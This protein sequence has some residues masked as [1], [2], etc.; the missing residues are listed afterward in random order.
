MIWNI[1]IIVEIII[2]II[3]IINPYKSVLTKFAVSFTYKK[4]HRKREN[5]KHP[6]NTKKQL[7]LNDKFLDS[8][9]LKEFA[10]DNF[11]FNENGRKFFKWVENNV[12]KREIARYEQ[13]LLYPY[14]FQRTCIA[15]T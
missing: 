9:K 2:I 10:D 15:D 8:Y 5:M 4:V 3:I 7:F 12:G 1:V 13:F 14:C 11:E 6:Q